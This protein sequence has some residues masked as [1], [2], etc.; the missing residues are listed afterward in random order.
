MPRQT[1]VT[2]EIDRRTADEARNVLAEIGLAEQDAIK[3]FFRQIAIRRALP[4]ALEAPP[5]P[6]RESSPPVAYRGKTHGRRAMLGETADGFVLLAGS[7]IAPGVGASIPDSARSARRAH[8]ADV[9]DTGTL[10]RDIP[11]ASKSAA[12]CFVCGGSVS[13]NVFWHD[14]R[15]APDGLR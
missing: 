14:V 3:L 4:F 6:A 9:D 5:L 1:T 11:F 10:L 15:R 2:F 7:R 13:G 8:A 12:A